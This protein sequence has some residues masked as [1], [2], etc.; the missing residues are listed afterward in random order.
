[1]QYR[2]FVWRFIIALIFIFPITI[3]AQI[4]FAVKVPAALQNP[5]VNILLFIL[6]GLTSILAVVLSWLPPSSSQKSKL[7]E[8]TSSRNITGR[9]NISDKPSSQ[10]EEL[11]K[12]Q[13]EKEQELLDVTYQEL[14]LERKRFD[15]EQ[16]RQAISWQ[17]E[18]LSLVNIS[19]RAAIL[20]AWIGV[21]QALNRTLDVLG[22]GD[23]TNKNSALFNIRRLYT[24]GQVDQK[25]TDTLFKMLSLR[26]QVVHGREE[27]EITIGEAIDLVQDAINITQELSSLEKRNSP[28]ESVS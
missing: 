16:E 3:L 18:A 14:A 10:L 1:M 7:T 9:I 17:K 27:K 20:I 24:F 19:P 21:E 28:E 23:S 12:E 22:L 2:R 13:Q 11:T 26:N 6:L 5:L 15:L 4:I 25:V 8:Q